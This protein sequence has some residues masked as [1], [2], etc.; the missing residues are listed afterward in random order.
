MVQKRA[1]DFANTER[2]KDEDLTSF[3]NEDILAVHP[4][5][6]RRFYDGSF[7]LRESNFGQCHRNL[8]SLPGDQERAAG[9]EVAD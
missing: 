8:L 2:D 4:L 5:N 3:V 6:P 7:I 9:A 1:S